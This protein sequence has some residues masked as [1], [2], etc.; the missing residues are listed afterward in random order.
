MFQG[1][2]NHRV[3]V[4][5]SSVRERAQALGEDTRSTMG[6]FNAQEVC[7]FA[8]LL[9]KYPE[10]TATRWKKIQAEWQKAID[11]WG[12]TAGDMSRC[13]YREQSAKQL[14]NFHVHTWKMHELKSKRAAAQRDKPAEEEQE[15]QEQQEQQQQPQNIE[16]AEEQEEQEPQEQLPQPQYAMVEQHVNHVNHHVTH[17]NEQQHH[18]HDYHVN[19]HHQEQHGY[20]HQHYQQHQYQYQHNHYHRHQH[21]HQY[22]YQHNHYPPHQIH[23]RYAQLWHQP[24]WHN[25]PINPVPVPQVPDVGQLGQLGQEEF[26]AHLMRSIFRH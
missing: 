5:R 11:R 18:H 26:E 21:Q 20:Q 12:N 6:N 25:A 1:R 3:R 23:H 16:D 15:Q 2:G 24:H 17:N 7:L 22:Q 10:G 9:D 14:N 19:E 4:D 13:P 8:G